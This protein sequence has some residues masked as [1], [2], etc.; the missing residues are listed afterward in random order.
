VKERIYLVINEWVEQCCDF[1]GTGVYDSKK[2]AAR[3]ARSSKR[4]RVVEYVRAD[5]AA[6]QEK[7]CD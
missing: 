4:Y 1:G 2:D 7:H 5:V 3:F 6:S